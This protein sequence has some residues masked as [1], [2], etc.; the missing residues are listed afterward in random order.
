MISLMQKGFIEKHNKKNGLVESIGFKLFK[1]IFLEI[2][3]IKI[4]ELNKKDKYYFVIKIA[5][6]SFNYE[7]IFFSL[8]NF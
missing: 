6:N 3:M 1:V 8:I 5:I 7:I 4:S 2:V